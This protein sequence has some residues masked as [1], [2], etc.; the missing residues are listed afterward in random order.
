DCDGMEY[1]RKYDFKVTP[2]E[3]ISLGDPV[4][5]SV[6]TWEAGEGWRA[7]VDESGANPTNDTKITQLKMH[8]DGAYKD[9]TYIKFRARRDNT[10]VEALGKCSPRHFDY[11]PIEPWT[12][13][14]V[15]SLTLALPTDGTEGEYIF[16]SGEG[17][18]TAVGCCAATR[19]IGHNPVNEVYIT[20]LEVR[21][22]EP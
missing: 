19:R 5:S 22:L 13:P 2:G 3:G 7:D 9:I 1:I 16:S 11:W 12:H 10:Y 21:Y 8:W 15:N 4:L 17:L 20:Y 6:M 18:K 14:N